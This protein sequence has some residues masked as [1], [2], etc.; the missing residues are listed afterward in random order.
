MQAP[1]VIIEAGASFAVAA[2]LVA[3]VLGHRPRAALHRTVIAILG[4]ILLWNA[5]ML[6]RLGGSSDLLTETAFRIQ[7]LGVFL[8]PPLFLFLAAR[9]ARLGSAEERPMALISALLVPSFLGYLALLSNSGHGLFSTRPFAEAAFLVPR[10]WGG[11]LFWL[12]AAWSYLCTQGGIA[13][14]LH[15]AWRPA[16]PL[17]RKRH[18]M[19]AAA[20]TAPLLANAVFLLGWVP[21]TITPAALAVTGL[22]IVAMILRYRLLEFAPLPARDVIARLR[23]GL[24]LTD[25]AGRVSD[26]NPAAE[27]LLGWSLEALRREKLTTL[28]ERLDASGDLAAA[29]DACPLDATVVRDVETPEGRAIEVSGGWMR[30][31]DGSAIG[32][33]LVFNDRTE[34]QRHQRLRHQAERLT[35]VAALAAG[36]AHEINNPLAYVSASLVELDRI[37]KAVDAWIEQNDGK[38]ADGLAEMRELVDDSLEGVG[39]IA[40]IVESTR[41]LSKD[42]GDQRDRVDLN[43]V[44]RDALQFASFH[45]NDAVSVETALDPDL[46]SLD[47]SSDRLGQVALNLLINDKYTLA[48]RPNGRIL[49]E[50]LAADGFV[51]LR[52]HDDGP[53][54]SQALRERIFEPFFT[55]KG[56]DQGTGLGLAIAYDVVRAH[57]GLIEVGESHLGGACFRVRLPVKAAPPSAN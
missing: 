1:V 14:C 12:T 15:A 2:A 13:I 39:R 34:Q 48:G 49:V 40:A 51:E 46:P 23:E 20:A 55:T 44:A 52:V 37:A 7:Y 22:L 4:T 31:R 19:L 6:L 43:A 21:V 29:I 17:D 45:E 32:R 8:L 54:V 57:D 38:Q 33:F 25:G 27:A 26:A 50:T 35:S 53:G 5:G 10:E 56:P 16:D 47:A 3:Y 11:P 9:C 30:G 42:P 28:V 36:L 24:V 41:R 18:L